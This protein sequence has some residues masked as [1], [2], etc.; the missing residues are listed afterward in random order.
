MKL[1][2]LVYK[3]NCGHLIE[4]DYWLFSIICDGCKKDSIGVKYILHWFWKCLNCNKFGVWSEDDIERIG[5]CIY[6]NEQFKL[7]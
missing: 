5:R 2:K 7:F 4:R 6:C 3:H 1:P